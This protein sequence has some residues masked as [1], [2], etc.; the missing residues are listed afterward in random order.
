MRILTPMRVAL[1]K[2]ERLSLTERS[3]WQILIK[4]LSSRFLA[5]VEAA[6]GHFHDIKQLVTKWDCDSLFFSDRLA[7]R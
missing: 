6:R 7:S 2:Y 5:D 1:I 4:N 3:N